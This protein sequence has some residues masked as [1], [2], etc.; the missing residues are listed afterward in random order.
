MR[1]PG[2]W[3]RREERWR[4]RYEDAW[5]RR[6]ERWRRRGRRGRPRWEDCADLADFGLRPW[7]RMHA[8]LH[9][10]IFLGFGVAIAISAGLASCVF[11]LS[12]GRARGVLLIPVGVVL[13]FASGAIAFRLIRPLLQVIRV[14]RDIGDGKLKS[15]LEL[16]RHDGDLGVLSD[17]INDMAARI[18]RQLADQRELLAAV[19]HEIRTPLGHMR[20]LLETARERCSDPSV[21]AELER[22]VLE[23][24]RLV[25]QLLAG[26]RLDFDALDRRELDTGE[27]AA[28]ALERAGIDLDRLEVAASGAMDTGPRVMGDPTLLARALANLIDNAEGHGGGLTCLRVRATG[29]ASPSGN[30]IHAGGDDGPGEVV[31]EIEDGGPGF[32]AGELDRVFESFYRGERRGHGSLGLG[33]A[34]VKRIAQAHHGRAW[35]ENRSGGGARLAFSLPR[36]PGD[37]G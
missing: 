14:A 24:D 18:E 10:R 16:G 6:E 37:G 8:G 30:G 17:S 22:E 31:F 26:S 9:W 13:W 7:W 29:G 36:N 1:P 28:L 19:S 21:V 33:L 23:V 3:D 27:L 12:D 32:A 25:G 4:Q 34:L 5:R 11:Y 35:A 20:I 2:Y 15:R